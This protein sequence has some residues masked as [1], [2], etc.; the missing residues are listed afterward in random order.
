MLGFLFIQEY[1]LSTHYVP[2]TSQNKGQN[3]E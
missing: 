1:L 3:S 2:G